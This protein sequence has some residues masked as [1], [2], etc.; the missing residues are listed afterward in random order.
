MKL[1]WLNNGFICKELYAPFVIDKDEEYLQ[2]LSEKFTIVLSQAN[3]A[4][5]D[6][7]SIRIIKK[8]KNKI[9]EA[10]RCY[11]RADISTAN[12]VI[13]NLLKEIGNN[14]LA[15]DELQKSAAFPGASSDELQFFRGRIGN[16]SNSFS[17]KDMLYL[18]S[19][20]R[21]KSGNYR[22]SIPGNPS[23]Y[24]ANTSYGCWI[25]TGFPADNDFNVSPV[26]LDGKQKI[27]N[28]AVSVRN[29]SRLN[30]CESETV[31]TWLKLLM[32]TIATSY[33]VK[34]QGRTFRSEYVV[35]Q[36]IMMGCKKLGYDGVAYYSKR[37]ADEAFALCA[38]NLALFVNYEDE[39]AGLINH[40]KLDDAFNFSV[41][42]KLLPFLTE[43]NYP[44]R[45]VATGFVTNIGSYDR[46]YSYRA[47]EFFEFDKFLFSTWKDKPNNKGKDQIQG[48]CK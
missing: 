45:S 40:I 12:I 43:K 8:F 33:R 4:G 38:I 46:Q 19:S 3:K 18:P 10:M 27:F 34:E 6:A 17:A 26:L 36:S 14:P 5:A 47:T 35:S 23:M 32:L 39:N 41:Y 9:L 7:D 29:F 16:P 24:L 20:L 15:V 25:E 1:T 2:D 22:F 42:K 48:V 28:L 30:E 44:L 13:K 11:Y 21:A 31:H 37:V